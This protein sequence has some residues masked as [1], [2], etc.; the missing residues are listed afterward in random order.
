MCVGFCCV[1]VSPS[2]K[3]HAYVSVSPSVSVPVAVNA[4]DVPVV[5]VAGR[6][7]RRRSP[8]AAR[9]LRRGDDH[10]TDMS[11]CALQKKAYSPALLNVQLPAHGAGMVNCGSG[12]IGKPGQVAVPAVCVHAVG[13]GPDR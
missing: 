11:P 3:S 13:C 6:G 5:D 4:I 12:G 1:D 10:V 7:A 9:W 2:P 8:S